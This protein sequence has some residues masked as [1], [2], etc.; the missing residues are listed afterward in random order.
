M[1][2]LKDLTPE[3]R[4]KIEE[5]KAKAREFYNGIPFDRKA[6]VAYIEFLYSKLSYEKP[7]VVF[8][9]DPLQYKFLCGFMAQTQNLEMWHD[10]KNG[11]L[12]ASKTKILEQKLK[13]ELED[14]FKDDPAKILKNESHYLWL[15]SPYT[16]AYLS[17]FHFICFELEVP[18]DKADEL[19]WMYN[20]FLKTDISR[21][22][23]ARGYCVVLRNPVDIKF[24]SESVLHNV[25]GPVYTY[26]TGVP[27]PYKINGRDIPSE[28]IEKPITKRMIL[29]EQNEDLKAAMITVI[30]ERDGQQALLDLLGAKIVDEKVI[31]HMPGYS[32]TVRLYKTREKFEI[33]NDRFGNANQPY[34]WVAIVCP[35]TGTEYLIDVSAD[36]TCAKKA[37]EWTRPSWVPQTL[38]Y[39]WKAFAN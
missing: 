33:L 26:R 24:N 38:K 28:L 25:N 20:T 31:E 1:K 3:K 27:G 22:F 18:Y 6:S 35:S 4:Q 39:K 37:L 12:P 19:D 16:R 36:F 13:K 10:I 30:K 9:D 14:I 2:T 21:C 32:E 29:D 5:Y 15:C 23:F 17:W 11:K 7:V 8:A 34:T